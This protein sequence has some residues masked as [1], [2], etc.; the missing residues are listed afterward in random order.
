[1][2]K[3]Q[4]ISKSD[5]SKLSQLFLTDKGIDFL[6]TGNIAGFTYL[7][8][9]KGLDIQAERQT[10]ATKANICQCGEYMTGSGSKKKFWFC[11]LWTKNQGGI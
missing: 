1:M 4:H 5:V 11:F 9:S 10:F 2:E 6:N 8:C 3:L 7:G